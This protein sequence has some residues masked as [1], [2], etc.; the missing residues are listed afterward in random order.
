MKG[1]KIPNFAAAEDNLHT[2]HE[3]HT[4]L[5]QH[6][7]IVSSTYCL[8]S[9]YLIDIST[10][11][12]SPVIY[13]PSPFFSATPQPTPLPSP[14]G[15]DQSGRREHGAS[16]LS[17]SQPRPAVEGSQLASSPQLSS[18]LASSSSPQPASS[19]SQLSSRPNGQAEFYSA[20]AANIK[21][22]KRLRPQPQR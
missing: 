2:A 6:Q 22:S 19:S 7:N 20:F 16:Q 15:S 18:Q 13:E 21:H 14:T 1:C 8:L 10:S 17:S 5:L 12:R 3:E 9:R 4:H 11:P